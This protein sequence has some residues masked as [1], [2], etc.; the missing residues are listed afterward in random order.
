MVWV[1]LI[2]FPLYLWHWPVLSFWTIVEGRSIDTAS[3]LSAV[4]VSVVLAWTTYRFVEQPIRTGTAHKLVTAG[5]LMA[6]L[7]T[8]LASGLLSQYWGRHYDARIAKIIRAWDFAGYPDPTGTLR[9]GKTGMV[10]IGENQTDRIL[11]VGDS[12][13]EQYE[14]AIVAAARRSNGIPPQ[15]AFHRI[16]EISVPQDRLDSWVSDRTIRRVIISYFWAIKYGSQKIDYGIR[17]C[18][19]GLFQ[20]TGAGTPAAPS[21]A[22]MAAVDQEL[23]RLLNALRQAGKDVYVVLDNPFGNELSPRALVRRSILRGLEIDPSRQMTYAD[24]IVRT[25]PSRS[26]VA[27][28]AFSTGAKVIDPITFLCDRSICPAVWPDGAPVYKDYDHLSLDTVRNPI[29]FDFLADGS[30]IDDKQS[31]A[32]AQAGH[33]Q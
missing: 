31:R 27:S 19:A 22:Q 26:R 33:D 13:A 6:C 16:Q 23:L 14:N 1:G 8:C 21:E 18:G 29:Y 11:L 3:R 7:V 30:L 25:E 28:I 4:V 10:V 12:H 17:C 20:T 32:T 2:S 15:V 9:D 5:A 24:A